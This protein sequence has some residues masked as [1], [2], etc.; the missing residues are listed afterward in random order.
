MLA[1]GVDPKS[2]DMY[3]SINLN[4]GENYG[5]YSTH[6]LGG[7]MRTIDEIMQARDLSPAWSLSALI[8][9]MKDEEVLVTYYPEEKEWQVIAKI[10]NTNYGC[11][12]D[13]PIESCVKMLELMYKNGYTLNTK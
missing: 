1:C 3:L 6:I 5:K 7:D 11:Y 8:D 4:E 2:A 9:M 13:S 10:Y 12:S